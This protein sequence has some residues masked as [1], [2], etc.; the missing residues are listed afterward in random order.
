MNVSHD[1]QHSRFVVPVSGG[2]AELVYEMVGDDA[3]DLQHTEV[4]PSD[5]NQ[6]VADALVLAAVAYAREHRLRVIPTC[7]YV[8]AWVRRHP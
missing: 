5:R 3:I 1:I 6:G 8:Q 4:P 2:E 7:P